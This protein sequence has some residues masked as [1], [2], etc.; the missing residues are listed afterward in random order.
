MGI[1]GGVRVYTEGHRMICSVKYLFRGDF[2][3]ARIFGDQ[4]CPLENPGLNLRK[5]FKLTPIFRFT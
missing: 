5:S 3:L 1:G 4:F 2:I